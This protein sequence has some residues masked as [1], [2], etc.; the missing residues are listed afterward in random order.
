MSDDTRDGAQRRGLFGNGSSTA[1]L[2]LVSSL[3]PTRPSPIMRPSP[4]MRPTRRRW[5]QAAAAA[6]FHAGLGG[7]VAAA[8]NP[9]SNPA[10]T[11]SGPALIAI[12]LDLE[13]S[14]QYPKRGMVE[15]NYEKGN[16]DEATKRY[17]LEAARMV[18]RAGGVLHF[19]C[20]GRVLEQPDVEWLREIAALGHPVG[21]HT[22]DHVNVKAREAVE[23]QFRFQRSP[24]LVAGKT[25]AELVREN[26]RV[27]SAALESRVR[28]KTNGFRTPGGFHNG[29]EDRPD[30]QELLLDLGYTWVSSKYPP[31][32]VGKP[33]EAPGDDVYAGIVAAQKAAQPYRY[34]TGLVE[35]PMSPIS[36]VT[37]FRSNQW[38][39]DYFLKAI[40]DSVDWAI[41]QRAVFDFLAHPSCLVVEDPEFA[42]IR[43]I[44]DRV[45]RAGAASAELV[46][47][48]RIA[49]RIRN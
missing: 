31:H 30:V 36:D 18:R 17:A 4:T 45:A 34:P 27:T 12:T 40:G 35:I 44:C 8:S 7:G 28:I 41:A 20:V 16:L 3:T 49:E 2:P 26:I 29:L 46:G 43:M 9:A 23:A 38:K 1:V 21:N 48:D 25:A 15:W 37:A 10:S 32:P 6:G 39:L 47:L 13:M 42:T 11:A 5:L 19:F 22:Y 14:A 33:G 24:W